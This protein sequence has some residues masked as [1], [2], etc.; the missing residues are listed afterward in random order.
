MIRTAISCLLACLAIAGSTPPAPSIQFFGDSTQV[1]ATAL[2]LDRL[3]SRIE[4]RA[5]GGTRSG[6]L[7]LGI[8]GMN[9]PWPGPVHAP[10][11]VINHGMNDARP[12]ARIPIAKYKANLRRLVREAPAEVI[13]ET[14]NPS[15]YPGRDTAPYAQAMR[16]VAAELGVQLIDVFSCFQQ[17][18]DWQNELTDQVHPSEV[19]MLWIV[20]HCV[21]PQ[22]HAIGS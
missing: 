17:L 7:L 20:D 8:D 4:M 22:L 15:T 16:E 5:V 11:V 10:R 14:P 12:W 2:L 19:G 9:T 18:P 13:L 6:M 3:G 1:M 21:V